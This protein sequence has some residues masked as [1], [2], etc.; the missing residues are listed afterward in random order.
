M[1]S[2]WFNGKVIHGLHNGD[3]FGFPTANVQLDKGSDIK[4]GVYAVIVKVAE[5]MYK[6]M[7]YVGTR[8][9]LHLKSLS[10]E[11]H[12]FNF[13]RDIYGQPIS[14]SIV[15]KIRNEKR[16]A[17]TDALIEQLKKDKAA[18]MEIFRTPRRRLAKKSDVPAVMEVIE[19]GRARLKGLHVDQ[20]QEGYPN[21][22]SIMQDVAKKQ[23]HVFVKGGKI[24]AYAAIV[25][26]PDPYYANINGNWLSDN[27]Y[28][29]VHRI[30]V[31]DR[32]AHQGIAKFILA[33]AEKMAQKKAVPSF[34]IDTHHDN[35][36]MRNLIRQCNF[37][38]CG[39][40]QVRDGKRMAYEKRI[41]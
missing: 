23:G 27:P 20:W 19:Q 38:L 29:V 14:F 33:S 13:H 15:E 32:H 25:F 34:R 24:V 7:L 3:S 5:K 28:V 1:S 12:I 18:V 26:E 8:P 21:E 9:T 41:L 11:I 37:T 39:I 16:F 30:A 6:G 2:I 4:K 17:N 10:F 31:C 40:V 22:E 35:R 36:Y